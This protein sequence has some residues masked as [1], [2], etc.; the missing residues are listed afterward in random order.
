MIKVILIPGNGG[1]SPNDNWFPSVQNELESQGVQ[2]IA[3]EFPDNDQARSNIWLPFL[4][5]ELGADE[6]TIL[7]GHSTGAIAAMRLA[8]ISPILGS[9]LVG[10]YHTDLKIE[11]EKLSGYFDQPWNWDKIKLADNG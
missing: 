1:G 11:K 10:A 7:V 9:V 2:V 4:L 6:N 3:D 5:N 8:E